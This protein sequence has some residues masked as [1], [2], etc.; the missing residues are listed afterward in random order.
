MNMISLVNVVDNLGKYLWQSS[1]SGDCT[2]AADRLQAGV[3]E[4]SHHALHV[5][6]WWWSEHRLLACKNAVLE[7]SGQV[8]QDA[9][10]LAQLRLQPASPPRAPIALLGALP[11]HMGTPALFIS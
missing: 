1:H 3:S 6:I 7:Q 4:A 11:P 10:Q 2:R 8:E 5:L 9:A